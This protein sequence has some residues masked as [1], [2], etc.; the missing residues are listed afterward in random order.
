MLSKRQEQDSKLCEELQAQGIYKDCL[1]CSCSVCIAQLPN[2]YKMGLKK[3]IEII[4]KEL[5][6][7]RRVD[8]AHIEID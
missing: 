3:A 1:G 5:E 2:Y 8:L 7:A 6:Y 4:D